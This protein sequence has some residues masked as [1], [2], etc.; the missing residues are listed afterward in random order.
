[1]A[2]GT[3]KSPSIEEP[4]YKTQIHR[5]VTTVE[6]TWILENFSYYVDGNEMLYS[7]PF[8]LRYG[9]PSFSLALRPFGRDEPNKE[10]VSLYLVCNDK[11][12]N[13]L[14]VEYEFSIVDEDGEYKNSEGNCLKQPMEGEGGHLGELSLTLFSP[15]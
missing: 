15:T 3:A 7:E 12:P 6:Q 1:M 13:H 4:K 2:D 9:Y 8:T 5:T 10:H 14:P 11:P